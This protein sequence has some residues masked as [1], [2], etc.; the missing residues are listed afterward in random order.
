MRT[1]IASKLSAGLLHI[2]VATCYGH[3]T[4]SK[5]NED[6]SPSSHSNSGN[7]MILNTIDSSLGSPFEYTTATDIRHCEQCWLP[8]GRVHRGFGQVLYRT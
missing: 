5:S 1:T 3:K 2:T 6:V 7:K 8:V 4:K